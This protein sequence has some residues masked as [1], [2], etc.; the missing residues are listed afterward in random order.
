M[1]QEYSF[2]EITDASDL[3]EVKKDWLATLA[4]PQDG[5]WEAFRHHAIDWGI[6]LDGSLIGYAVIND[7]NQLLQFYLT[8]IHLAN[9]ESIFKNFVDQR[10]IQ[11]G[12]V[13]TNNPQFLSLTLHFTANIQ[14]HS[15]LFRA[16]HPVDIATK[17]GELKECQK[18]DLESV[19]N[20][21]H[22]SIGAPKEWLAVYLGNLIERKEI[23]FLEKDDTIIGT[24]EV[25]KSKT[26]PQYAD[27]G[28]IVSPDFRKQGYG[29]FLLHEAKKIAIQQGRIPICSCEKDNL[30]SLKAIHNAGFVS[31]YRLL[32]VNFQ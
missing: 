13:G 16:Y 19:I 28:M 27:I 22:Y 10:N 1:K 32:T 18:E 21:C 2:K 9:G 14:V 31:T 6:Y 24:C 23:F 7:E 3:D 17:N 15:Y 4:S 8:P 12:I 29:T 5:M 20:F 25:R 11:S 26:A 30:G